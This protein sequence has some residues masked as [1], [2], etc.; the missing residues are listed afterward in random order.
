MVEV[1]LVGRAAGSGRG[2][3]NR[4]KKLSVDMAVLFAIREDFLSGRYKS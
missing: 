4:G 2:L 3:R 1:G